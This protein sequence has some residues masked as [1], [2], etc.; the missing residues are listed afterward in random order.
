MQAWYI[1]NHQHYSEDEEFYSFSYRMMVGQLGSVLADYGFDSLQSS[2]S[3]W[4]RTNGLWHFAYGPHLEPKMTPTIS[5]VQDLERSEKSTK[6]K[7]TGLQK[8][9]E[10]ARALELFE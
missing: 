2:T 6:A 4:K 3:D 1:K 10:G 9:L 5:K 8:Q 7:L